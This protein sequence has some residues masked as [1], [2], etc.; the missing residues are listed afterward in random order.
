MQIFL[1]TLT[2]ALIL[3]LT[4]ALISNL[5]LTLNLTLI[6]TLNLTLILTSKPESGTAM[7]TDSFPMIGGQVVNQTR[8]C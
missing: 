7:D 3:N 6:L 8:L 4:L 5:T 2:L 1:L